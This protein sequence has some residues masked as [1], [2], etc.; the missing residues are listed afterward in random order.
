MSARLTSFQLTLKNVFIIRNQIL[1]RFL[2]TTMSAYRTTKVDVRWRGNR[3]N[4]NNYIKET[5]GKQ[6]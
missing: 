2:V 5:V 6:C 3:D 4:L 1:L